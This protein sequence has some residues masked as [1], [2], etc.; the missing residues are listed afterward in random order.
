MNIG[1]IGTQNSHAGAYGKVINLD[2]LFP[3]VAITHAWGETPESARERAAETQ[4]PTVVDAPQAMLG[5]I[6][7]LIIDTR[8]G[9]NHLGFAAPFLGAGI[10]IFIDKPLA[11]DVAQAAAF[12]D[13]A[14]AGGTR[15]ASHSVIP[16]Q[17]SFHDFVA[18]TQALEPLRYVGLSMPAGIDSE[19]SGVFFY[20]IHAVECL[21]A[22]LNRPPARVRIE[23]FA[24]SNL[25]TL[26][27]PD[28]PLATINLQEGNYSYHLMAAGDKDSLAA[29]LVY[30]ADP[31]LAGIHHIVDFFNGAAPMDS[32]E[33]LLMPVQILAALET[34]KVQGGWVDVG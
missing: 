18:A 5:Q 31:Y 34:S 10:P 6:D 33:R 12:L 3:G 17:Q 16:L 14:S 24:G 2:K 1:L 9:A 29:R 32:R 19:Y 25:A 30:D 22:L 11:T 23:R 20:V 8:D 26:D 21:C 7:A 15:V 13:N 27:Y 4:I 28:G